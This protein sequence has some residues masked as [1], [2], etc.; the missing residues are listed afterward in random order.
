MTLDDF[1]SNS[2]IA[3][4]QSEERGQAS[5]S[6]PI[7]GPVTPWFRRIAGNLDCQLKK[8]RVKSSPEADEGENSKGRR[9]G[10]KNE[11]KAQRHPFLMSKKEVTT[12][13]EERSQESR[14]SEQADRAKFVQELMLATI[15][16]QTSPP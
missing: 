7:L 11:E 2:S 8:I 15:Q 3:T 14:E 5:S 6:R 4:L 12:A 13:D 9:V 10:M 1:Q 16:D